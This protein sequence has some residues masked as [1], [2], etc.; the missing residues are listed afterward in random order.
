MVAHNYNP[1]MRKTEDPRPQAKKK[2]KKKNTLT[3]K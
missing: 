1:A 2:N 3:E